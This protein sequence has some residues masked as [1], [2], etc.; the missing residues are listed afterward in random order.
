MVLQL[1]AHMAATFSLSMCA[2]RAGDSARITSTNDSSSRACRH[3][4]PH[5]SL[6]KTKKSFSG[7][8]IL[9]RCCVSVSLTE[10]AHSLWCA[11]AHLCAAV[12]TAGQPGVRPATVTSRVTPHAHAAAPA[13]GLLA[14]RPLMQAQN[15]G[16]QHP[17]VSQIPQGP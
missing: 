4:N 16:R 10:S 14:A 9:R 2:A 7:E 8:L 3:S 11:P 6:Q 12:A 15:L 1:F 5:T 17:H 13:A